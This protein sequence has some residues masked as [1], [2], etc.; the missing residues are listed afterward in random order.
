MARDYF[1]RILRDAIILV[2][3]DSKKKV[4]TS[5]TYLKSLKSAERNFREANT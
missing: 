3:G 1:H 5:Q 4:K 2:K